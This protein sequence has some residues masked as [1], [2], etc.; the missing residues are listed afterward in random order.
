[1]FLSPS[2]S[3]DSFWILD[4]PVRKM[5]TFGGIGKIKVLSCQNQLLY[6]KKD[7]SQVSNKDKL[8][9]LGYLVS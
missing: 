1:M 3:F 7:D 2:Y 6:F 5:G 8:V 9:K 4:F